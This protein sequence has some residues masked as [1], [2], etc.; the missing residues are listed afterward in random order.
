R[1]DPARRRNGE[2]SGIGL[3]IVKSIVTAHHGRIQA[4]SDENSTR[5]IISFP[6]ITD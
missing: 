1:V 5:F 4:E 2:G 3:A 6:V